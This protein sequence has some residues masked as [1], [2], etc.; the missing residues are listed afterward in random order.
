MGQADVHL[1]SGVARAARLRIGDFNTQEVANLAW[2][3]AKSYRREALLF[4]VLAKAAKRRA[5]A[6]V[7][8]Q[9]ATFAWAMA[10]AGFPLFRVPVGAVVHSAADLDVRGLSA[11]LWSLSRHHS[12]KDDTPMPVL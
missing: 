10:T 11:A 3:F 9:L 7:G 6:F 1:C 2:A 4:K 8:T 5:S 12:F